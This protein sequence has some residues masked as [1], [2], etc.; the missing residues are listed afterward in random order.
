MN[1]DLEVSESILI[2]ASAERVWEVLTT[3][4][5]ISEYLYG[6][7]TITDWKP[8]SEII[9]QGEYENTKYRDK[10]FILENIPLKKIS[11]SYW[12]GF[13]GLAD[14]PENYSTVIYLLEAKGTQTLF[15]WQQKGFADES[16]LEHSK[17]GMPAFLEQIKGIAERD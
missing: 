5:I 9:F 17:S 1:H 2:N 11:Y 16:R 13:S 15:T 14:I 7:E 6:T 12:S 3:P 8:G 4:A 10:G